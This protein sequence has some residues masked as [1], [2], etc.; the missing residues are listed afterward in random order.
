MRP[1]ILPGRASQ[2][3]R[4]PCRARPLVCVGIGARPHLGGYG[5]AVGDR[6]RPVEPR[7]LVQF[8]GRLHVVLHARPA[9]RLHDP[10]VHVGEEPV[11]LVPLLH[12]D[13]LDLREHP[14]ARGPGAAL[15]HLQ[16]RDDGPARE[17]RVCGA[18]AR[19]E[20]RALCLL[21]VQDRGV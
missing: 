17:R 11:D 8:A 12:P 7:V 2:R 6:L 13:F 18:R 20:R 21:A 14:P 5:V 3:G 16:L 4:A 1:G 19:G 15:R 9:A 10:G